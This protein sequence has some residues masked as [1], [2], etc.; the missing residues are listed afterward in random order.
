[1]TAGC[2]LDT[3]VLLYAVKTTPAEA[4]KR[5]LAR[6]LLTEVDWTL[7]VQVLQEFYVQATRATRPDRLSLDDAVALMATWERFTVQPIDGAVLH[8]AL[9]LH[10]AARKIW[11]ARCQLRRRARLPNCR[12]AMADALGVGSVGGNGTGSR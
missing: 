7:S 3:N 5:Q 1:M 4:S 9:D 6:Y 11:P 12:R 10:Q 8:R 2:F